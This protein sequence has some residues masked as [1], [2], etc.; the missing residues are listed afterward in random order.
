M[1]HSVP[2][3][4]G[5]ER[6]L[7]SITNIISSLIKSFPLTLRVAVGRAN[8]RIDSGVNRMEGVMMEAFCCSITDFPYLSS[9][10]FRP[11]RVSRSLPRRLIESQRRGSYSFQQSIIVNSLQRLAREEIRLTS[12]RT[13]ELQSQ[14]FI[15]FIKPFAVINVDSPK[16]TRICAVL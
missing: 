3:V 10:C 14:L 7:G 2:F 12:A 4:C 8:K 9:F 11:L 5:T 16:E 13:K 1:R 6:L 15:T